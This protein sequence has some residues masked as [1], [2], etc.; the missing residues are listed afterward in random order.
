MNEGNHLETSTEANPTFVFGVIG[1]IF[2]LIFVLIIANIYKMYEKMNN[3]DGT[4]T[5]DP[6]YKM[7]YPHHPEWMQ[8]TKK[9]YWYGLM[10]VN[11]DP[12]ANIGNVRADIKGLSRSYLESVKQAN[13]GWWLSFFMKD[14]RFGDSMRG[15][16]RKWVLD[17][18]T[19]P[20]IKIARY[21]PSIISMGSQF[22]GDFG[23]VGDYVPYVRYLGP[24]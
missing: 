21:S 9:S 3:L 11:A 4:W 8:F 23:S 12:R 17:D 15:S 10:N 6:Q 20:R 18:L 13:A 14:D 7:Q 22:A 1:L 16:S 24:R 19:S 2:M 5:I